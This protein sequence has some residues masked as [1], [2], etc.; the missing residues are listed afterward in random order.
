[1]LYKINA[2]IGV[3]RKITEQFREFYP[4]HS[5]KIHEILNGVDIGK[6][7]AKSFRSIIRKRWNYTNDHFVIGTVANFRKVKNHACL[8]RAAARLTDT[9]PQLRLFFV[10]RGFP[11]DTENTEEEVRQ[12]IF[13]LGLQERVIMAGYQ[14]KIPDM[15]SA[16][17]VFCLPSLSEGLP[18][19]VLEAMAAGIPVIGSNVLGINEVIEDRVTGLLFSSDNDS[20]LAKSVEELLTN[21]A[22]GQVLA[23]KAFNYVQQ[24]H[25]KEEWIKRT[26]SLFFSV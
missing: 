20:G 9:Y 4:H 1:M 21:P 13:D 24:R 23:D 11:G 10:G 6:F 26:A 19:S 7:N 16:F 15:L 5:S 17:D 14:D 3:S 8:V 25:S 12:L 18:V 22:L 2:V